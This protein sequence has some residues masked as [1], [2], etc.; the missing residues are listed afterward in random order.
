MKIY[1]IRHAKSQDAEDGL[2]Q[3]DNSPIIDSDIDRNH[4][5][6]IQPQKVYVSPVTRAQQTAQVLFDEFEVLDYIYEHIPPRLL[7]GQPKEIG[8]A[9][10]DKHLPEMI[11][12]H[13]W[14]HDGGES[15]NAII[16][17]VKR[18]YKHLSNLC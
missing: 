11:A 8:K 15:F 18:F 16:K 3:R 17:R 12:D 14:S 1:L 9:F 6:Y 5:K 10:W 2:S 7:Q 4:F 13:G